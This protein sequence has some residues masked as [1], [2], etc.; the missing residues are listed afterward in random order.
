[1]WTREYIKTRAKAVLKLIYWKAFA[2]SLVLILVGGDSGMGTSGSNIRGHN[3]NNVRGFIGQPGYDYEPYF[4]VALFVIIF[5]TAVLLYRILVGYALEVGGRRFFK[6]AAQMDVNMGY[7]GYA[8]KRERYSHVTLTMLYKG[9]LIF[10]WSLLLI[11]PGV[12]KSYAYSMVPYILADNPN[13]GYSRAIQLS[14][15]M[16]DGHKFDMWVLDLS[17]I[18]W[19]LLGLL[20]FYVGVLFVKPYENATKAELYLILRQNALENAY[21]TSDELLMEN[22]I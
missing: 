2:I 20:L 15:Q 18:G 13:I 3:S 1:M 8:F 7:L 16:T 11:I 12:I 10:L 14:N 4:N 6:Q 5:V 17:F 19:Y 22:P 9:V 21:C